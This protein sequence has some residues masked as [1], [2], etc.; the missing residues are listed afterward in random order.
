MG[1][2]GD[3]ENEH[4]I[5]EQLN[6]GDRLGSVALSRAQ[7]PSQEIVH[8]SPLRSSSMMSPETLTARLLRAGVST[9]ISYTSMG[10]VA[11]GSAWIVQ[12]PPLR[13]VLAVAN[14]SSMY[15]K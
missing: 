3:R 8:L 9:N 4:Q 1:E 2:L 10:S 6:R 5:E 14:V 13:N 15:W 11:D 12:V 7:V